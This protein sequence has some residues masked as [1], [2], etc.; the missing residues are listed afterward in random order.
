M[1]ILP[2]TFVS[3]IA[4]TFPGTVRVFQAHGLEFCCGGKRPLAEVCADAG[5]AGDAIIG[6]L[7]AAATPREHATADWTQ[8]PIDQ[9]RRF[10]LDIYHAPLRV[11][12]PRLAAMARTVERVHGM[13]WPDA[14]PSLVRSVDQLQAAM[15]DQ[16]SEEEAQLFPMIAELAAPGYPAVPAAGHSRLAALTSRVEQQHRAIGLQLKSMAVLTGWYT[17]P[18]GACSTMRALYFDLSRLT[19]DTYMHAHLEN[20]ILFPRVLALAGSAPSYRRGEST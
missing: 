6:E 17:P 3:D 11:E 14:V 10:I 16:L 20:N 1:L 8:A 13:R 2:T 9:L 12:L 5:I 18:V 7:E 4:A 15:L 19:D